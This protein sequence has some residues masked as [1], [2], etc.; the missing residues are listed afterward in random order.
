MR[1]S[2]AIPADPFARLI[3][4]WRALRGLTLT[5]LSKAINV[6]HSSISRWE[7]STKTLDVHT[8][9]RICALLEIPADAYA[10]PFFQ[11][12]WNERKTPRPR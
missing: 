1:R 7:R 6:G 8:A 5:E 9:A 2:E 3:H 10:A 4:D 12:V 11:M